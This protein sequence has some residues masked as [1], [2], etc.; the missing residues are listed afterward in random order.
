MN[1]TKTYTARDIERYHSGELSAAERH[2]LEKAALDDPFLAD[3]LEGYASA[4]TPATDVNILRQKLQ[5]RIEKDSKRKG[6]FYTGNAWMKVAALFV[7]IAGSGWL[8]VKLLSD[9]ETKS[10]NVIAFKKPAIDSKESVADSLAVSSNTPLQAIPVQTEN[11]KEYKQR[12]TAKN[13][14]AGSK[15]PRENNDNTPEAFGLATTLDSAKDLGYATR[16]AAP[17]AV[18]KTAAFKKSDAE[19]KDKE[20]VGFADTINNFNVTLKRNDEGLQEVVIAKGR[21]QAVRK[22]NVTIDS[23]EP[24]EGWTNFDDYVAGHLHEPEELKEK[25][26]KGEVELSFDVNKEGEPVNITV[27]QSLCAKCDEEAVRLLKEGPKWK[28]KKTK[29]KIKIR[30]PSMPQ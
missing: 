12:A 7:L 26:I 28:N 1:G 24:S 13:V 18:Q 4:Q 22:A 8:M 10:A 2:A 6:L 27:T 17:L 20:Q 21:R 25:G 19:A 5:L 11:A 16:Q 14:N 15:A 23:L 3:A 30:F 9:K 29:G